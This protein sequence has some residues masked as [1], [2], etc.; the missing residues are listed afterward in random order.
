MRRLWLAKICNYLMRSRF[1]CLACFRLLNGCGA[2][3]PAGTHTGTS[4]KMARRQTETTYLREVFSGCRNTGRTKTGLE[5]YQLVQQHLGFRQVVCSVD[6]LL[7]P[8]FSRD[9]SFRIFH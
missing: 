3:K 1:L 9:N 2:K 5:S 7:S 4:R 8:K 6:Q